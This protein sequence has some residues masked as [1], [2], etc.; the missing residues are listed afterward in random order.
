[1]SL[2]HMA[3]YLHAKGHKVFVVLP[4]SPEKQFET[5]LKPHIEAFLFVPMMAWN[6]FAGLGY[7]GALRAW[8]YRIFKSRGGWLHAPFRI[9]RFIRLHKI[10]LVHTNTIMAL[11]GAIAAKMTGVSHVQ[12]LREI[13][14]FHPDSNIKMLGQK[15]PKAFKSMMSW[16]N[17][18]IVANST[19]VAKAA[20]RFFPAQKTRLAY[21][22]FEFDFLTKNKV[23]NTEKSSA[24]IGLVANVT[25]KWKNHS[26]FIAVAEL[27]SKKSPGAL[28]TF[29]L[30]GSLPHNEDAYFIGLKNQIHKAELQNIVSFKGACAQDKMYPE[31]DILLHSTAREPFGRIFIEAMAHGIPVVAARGGG[32][33]ELIRD[34]ENGFL[35]DEN[36]LETAVRRISDLLENAALYARISDNGRAFAQQFHSAVT[37]AALLEIYKEVLR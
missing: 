18:T 16:L 5:L 21:N 13:T 7:W 9:A 26:L 1:M 10:D 36:D 8:T 3:K 35:F 17:N 25:S 2:L 14:G 32:A 29:S 30:Y 27:F 19:Y 33:D 15:H 6:C 37:G 4:P 23:G 28:V 22:L 12:H 31:I 34:N 24:N 11:D 20:V